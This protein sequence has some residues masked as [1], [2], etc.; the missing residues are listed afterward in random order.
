MQVIEDP[1]RVRRTIGYAYQSYQRVKSFINGK[2][3]RNVRHPEW[4]NRLL[5]QFGR[6]DAKTFNVMVA[7]SKGKGSHA[8]L[9]AAMLQRAGIRTGLF[10]GP[11]HVDFM[12]R[13]RINGRVIPEDTF[14][15][16]MEQVFEASES[17][18]LP[19]GQYVWAGRPSR[20]GCSQMV[21]GRGRRGRRIRMWPRRET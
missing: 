15:D 20:S 4:T 11:H 3:D 5:E 13:F 1:V 21:P 2:L 17:L 7:G 12:E 14:C 16:Y 8:T 10:T 6:P 19:P 9:T 18:P